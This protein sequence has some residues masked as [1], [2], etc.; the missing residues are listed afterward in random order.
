MDNILST[1]F[2]TGFAR[3]GKESIVQSALLL[4]GEWGFHRLNSGSLRLLQGP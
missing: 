1:G 2:H 3:E 4:E